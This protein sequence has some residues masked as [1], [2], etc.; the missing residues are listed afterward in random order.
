M[1]LRHLLSTSTI[2]S[3]HPR[4]Y[5]TL[6]PLMSTRTYAEAIERLNSLQSNAATLDAVRASGGRLSE[7]AIPEM[8]EYWERM[9]YKV[10]QQR[11]YLFPVGLSQHAGDGLEQTERHSC[12]RDERERLDMCLRQLC[13]DEAQAG[14]EVRCVV[15]LWYSKYPTHH[16]HRSIHVASPRRCTGA[17]TSERHTFVRRTLCEILLRSV[18]S[19]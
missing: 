19:A 15:V 9:G 17:D 5:R 7:F 8:I 16:S 6:A 4:P 3:S 12:H 13:L 10:S 2:F 14:V 11:L 1:R 18:G